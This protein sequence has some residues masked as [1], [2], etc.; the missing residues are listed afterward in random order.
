[1]FLLKPS[2]KPFGSGTWSPGVAAY[3]RPRGPNTDFDSSRSRTVRLSLVKLFE[4]STLDSKI[5][6]KALYSNSQQY[7]I[8]SNGFLHT[9]VRTQVTT[10][11]NWQ[12]MDILMRRT[13]A[14]CE[15][16]DVSF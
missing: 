11:R 14:V 15:T 9:A 8:Y 7:S 12:K 10:S 6:E 2:L 5:R 4:V 1:M 16:R 3:F 13:K